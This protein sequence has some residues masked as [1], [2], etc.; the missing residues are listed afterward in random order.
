MN[1]K[2]KNYKK[3]LAVRR[4]KE[5]IREAKRNLGYEKLD[6]PYQRGWDAYWVLRDDISK[7]EDAEEIQAI[8]D[9]Y[10]TTIYS[11]DG[12]FVTWLR[13][14][15]R[16][17]SHKPS[18]KT[19]EEKEYKTLY[20]W[21][22]KWFEHDPTKDKYSPWHYRTLR[23]YKCVIPEYFL[24]MKK[25]KHWVTHH[26]VVDE[27]LEQEW[28]ELDVLEDKLINY[29]HWSSFGKSGKPYKK[30]RNKEFRLKEKREIKKTMRTQNWDDIDLPIPKNCVLW[31]MY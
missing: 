7:R 26:K 31:D 20:S 9:H 8:I 12:E 15:K 30:F 21:A 3:Y 13:K 25:V 18:I 24:V 2:D 1:S 6:K 5:E 23:Y 11:K 10:G 28:A 16:Y 14:E 19:I 4:R 17:I 29:R 22:Q 27:V